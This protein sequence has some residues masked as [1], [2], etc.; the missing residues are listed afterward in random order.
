MSQTP[1]R[2]V[3][4][5]RA[6]HRVLLI[7]AGLVAALC[8]FTAPS[9]SAHTSAVATQHSLTLGAALLSGQLSSAVP[10]CVSARQITL[11]RAGATGATAVSSTTTGSTGAWTRPTSGLQDGG[12]Y[13]VAAAKLITQKGHKHTCSA[14]TSNTVTLTVD[15]DGDGYLAGGGDC[16]DANPT[17]HPGATEVGNGVDDDCDGLVDEGLPVD[18]DSDGYPAGGGDCNDANPAV[19][20]GAIEV[21]NNIDDDCDGLVDEGYATGPTMCWTP[22]GDPVGAPTTWS[23]VESNQPCTW[24]LMTWSVLPGR[25][26][27]VSDEWLI[28]HR[29]AAGGSV[30]FEYDGQGWAYYGTEPNAI[31]EGA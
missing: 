24:E 14:A 22:A 18:A 2:P 8:G 21:R 9:A 25:V 30:A 31:F 7:V 17:V 10:E 3:A 15:A 16:N 13:A 20:P 4:A 11:Y 29:P 27:M 19:H 28:E 12:Y 1:T 5:R 6:R 23:R 26:Y